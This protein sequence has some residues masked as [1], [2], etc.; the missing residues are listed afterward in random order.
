[1]VE[2]ERTCFEVV[3]VMV[4]LLSEIPLDLSNFDT[5]FDWLLTDL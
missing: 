1:M 4:N 5:L 2:R 3:F